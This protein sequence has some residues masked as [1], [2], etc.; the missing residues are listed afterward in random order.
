M[1][2]KIRFLNYRTSHQRENQGFLRTFHI[3]RNRKC[4]YR[5]GTCLSPLIV[6]YS[7]WLRAWG[8]C[9]LAVIQKSHVLKTSISEQVILSRYTLF[10]VI[11]SWIWEL[12]CYIKF[13]SIFICTYLVHIWRGMFSEEINLECS[14][15]RMHGAGILSTY[16]SNWILH[17]AFLCAHCWLVQGKCLHVF[18]CLIWLMKW[19]HKA[20]QQMHGMMKIHKI[21]ATAH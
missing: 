13:C 12:K 11:V 14:T 2:Q 21:E 8:G 10:C 17:V 7:L 6:L 5:L 9:Q 19:S 15:P 3:R 20:S 4:T 1:W 16:A 18:L